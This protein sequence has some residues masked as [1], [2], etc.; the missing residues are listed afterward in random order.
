MQKNDIIVEEKR[1][2]SIK[3]TGM[4]SITFK[5]KIC[6]NGNNTYI[7]VKKPVKEYFSEGQDVIVT[8]RPE[9]EILVDENGNLYHESEMP[10]LRHDNI[11]VTMFETE[12][13]ACVASCLIRNTIR[14]NI[15]KENNNIKKENNKAEF[16]Y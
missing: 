5:A 4:K 13:D 16:Q 10:K 7:T 2:C 9:G 14:E 15:K 8:M 6:T 1:Y 12:H 11:E 3:N